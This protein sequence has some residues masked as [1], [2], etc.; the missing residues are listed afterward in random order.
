MLIE[1]RGAATVSIGGRMLPARHLALVEPGGASRELWVD[2]QGR[3]LKVTIASRGVT[4][5][6]D[7][8][9]R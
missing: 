4:A 1:E 6:R 7:D 9:P 8:P 2:A 5:V 3:V